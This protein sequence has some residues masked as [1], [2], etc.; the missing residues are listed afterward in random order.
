M[1]S[2]VQQPGQAFLLDM[3]AGPTVRLDTSFDTFRLYMAQS[4]IDELAYERGL[5]LVGGLR[6]AKMGER[7]PVLFHLAMSLTPALE[8]PELAS[9]AFLDYLGLALHAH[10]VATYGGRAGRSVARGGGLA[11]WQMRRL[12]DLV[13]AHPGANPSIQELAFLC[14]LSPSYFSQAFRRSFGMPPHQ[15]LLRRRI[16]H[17]RSLLSDTA[18]S[19]AAIAAECGFF[20]Q[21]HFSRVFTRTEH[22][23]PTTWRRL[24]Q[25]DRS[26]AQS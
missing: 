5:R 19:L 11:P 24:H 23:N 9:A 18:L 14:D 12:R 21:S 8:T 2:G 25:T 1:F 26:P 15:W 13:D 20:D 4:A 6:Q 3:S 10:V 22:V 17:A 7:D 16:E